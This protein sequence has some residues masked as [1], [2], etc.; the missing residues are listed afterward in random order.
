MQKSILLMISL[1]SLIVGSIILAFTIQASQLSEKAQNWETTPVKFKTLKY[2]KD[3]YR[4]SEGRQRLRKTLLLSYTYNVDNNEMSSDRLSFDFASELTDKT[5]YKR[6]KE[7]T[8]K[9]KSKT[10]IF[11]YYDPQDPSHAVLYPNFEPILLTLGIIG[12]V[13]FIC[14]SFALGVPT[15]IISARKNKKLKLLKQHKDEPWLINKEWTSGKVQSRKNELLIAKAG[16][17]FFCSLFLAPFWLTFYEDKEIIVFLLLGIFQLFCGIVPLFQFL[18]SLWTR[19]TDTHFSLS[20]NQT[21]FYIGKTAEGSISIP[22]KFQNVKYC[23]ATMK[24]VQV[25]EGKKDMELWKNSTNIP[26]KSIKNGAAA[27]SLQINGGK[28]S[29][30]IKGVKW[31]LLIHSD[32]FQKEFDIPIFEENRPQT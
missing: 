11:C 27:I 22:A 21:P 6:Y 25:R 30:E 14:L 17:A 19:T 9:R 16:M 1:I 8:K 31:T 20:L 5:E 4:D 23:T 28:T 15:L 18:K 26:P 7:L 10:H 12:A 29:D 2:E 3:Y 32:L 13:F 24:C